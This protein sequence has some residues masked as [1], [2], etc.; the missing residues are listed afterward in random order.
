MNTQKDTTSNYTI[1]EAAKLSGLSESTLRYYETIGIIDPINRDT[2]SKHRRYSEQDLDNVISIAC[3]NAL[4]MSIDDMHTY[5]VNRFKS[6]KQATVQVELLEKQ[7]E[8]LAADARYLKLRQQYVDQKIM[9]WKAVVGGNAKHIKAEEMKARAIG[10]KL[11]MS[12][13]KHK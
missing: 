3:L 2:S 4:G 10:S 5:M 11:R 12:P 7:K 9:Y 6:G 1:Q 8:V 13:G